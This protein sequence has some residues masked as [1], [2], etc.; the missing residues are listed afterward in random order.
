MR[1]SKK[2]GA[3]ISVSFFREASQVGKVNG[4]LPPKLHRALQLTVEG[5]LTSWRGVSKSFAHQ[6]L[7]ASM[8]DVG[9]HIPVR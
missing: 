1:N 7:L 2:A 8:S 5:L 6:K 3:A 9:L 4:A